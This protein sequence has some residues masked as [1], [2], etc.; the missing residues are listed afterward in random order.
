MDATFWQS[1]LDDH[2]RALIERDRQLFW[3][4]PQALVYLPQ[5]LA[6]TDLKDF[7]TRALEKLGQYLEQLARSRSES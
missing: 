6:S 4:P 7:Q 2:F 5:V 1:K 3:Q